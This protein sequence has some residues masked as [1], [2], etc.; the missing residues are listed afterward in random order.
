MLLREDCYIKRIENSQYNERLYFSNRERLICIDAKTGK[1]INSFGKDGNV[2]TGLNV[3]TPVI[4]KNQIIIATWDRSVEVYDLNS[5]KKWKI[6]YKKQI[7]R[8]IG[9]KKYNNKG[10]NPWEEFL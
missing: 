5:G 3:L 1:Q 8:R 2:R 6:K 4:Y 7:N 10:G 9:G